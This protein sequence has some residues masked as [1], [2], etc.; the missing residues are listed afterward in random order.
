M[1]ADVFAALEA[2]LKPMNTPKDVAECGITERTL[3]YWRTMGLGPKFV[4]VG[5][6]VL[7][8]K[9]ELVSY[10][11]EHLYQSTSEYGDGSLAS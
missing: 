8:P 7:Y 4:K 11:R 10:F 6:S 2:V 5:R 9:E 1:C 3:A